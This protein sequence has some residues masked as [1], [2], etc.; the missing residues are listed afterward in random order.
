M[1]YI[2]KI[3]RPNGEVFNAELPDAFDNDHTRLEAYGRGIVVK[4]PN[5]LPVYINGTSKQISYD[6]E[7]CRTDLIIKPE[8]MNLGVKNA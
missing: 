3:T 4:T 2:V 1:P 6:P 8:Y 5:E 7:V